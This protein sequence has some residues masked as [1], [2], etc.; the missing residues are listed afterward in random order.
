MKIFVLHYTK[1]TDRKKNI[2][3][4]FKKHN[5]IDYEFI[6]KFDKDEINDIYNLK[7]EK[8]KLGSASLILKHHYVYKQISEFNNDNDNNNNNNNNN[9]NNN[10][11]DNDFLI[12]EDDVI[13]TDNFMSILNKYK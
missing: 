12:L 10:D 7:F 1:L 13:L 9:G 6:E 5:I 4:Q 11:N 3:L 8:I 2:I